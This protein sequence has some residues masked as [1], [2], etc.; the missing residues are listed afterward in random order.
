MPEKVP[1]V[2]TSDGS[3][4]TGETRLVTIKELLSYRIS[5]VANAMSR[6][7]ALRYRRDFN[8]SLGEWRII[9]LLGSDAPLTHNNLARLAALD[10]AQMSRAVTKLSNRGLILREFGAGRTTIL[11]LTRKGQKLYDGLIGAANERDEAFLAC[12]TPRE[13]TVLDSALKKLSSFASALE[14]S[15]RQADEAAKNGGAAST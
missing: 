12:L 14:S 4:T 13:R 9:A 1:S 6:S 11:S 3:Q 2:N 10:K 8:V 5:R 7:A 15:E